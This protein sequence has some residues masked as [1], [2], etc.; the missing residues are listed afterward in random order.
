VIWRQAKR[1]R[2]RV[3]CGLGLRF[4][5]MATRL[6]RTQP[7]AVRKDPCGREARELLVFLP[8]VFD[9]VE[10]YEAHGFLQAVRETGRAVDMLL[11]DAHLGY[12]AARTVLE[13]LR[14]DVI[15][16]ARARYESIRLIGIS[17]GG[18]GALLYAARYPGHVTDVALLAP[19]LGKAG[20]IE[21]IRAAGGLR[22]WSPSPAGELEYQQEL[23]GWLKAYDPA[24]REGPRIVLGY[25]LQ[26]RTVPGLG[27][28]AGVLPG[29]HVFTSSGR[30]DWR[31]WTRL[32]RAMLP[33]VLPATG[34]E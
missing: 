24:S 13:R 2:R 19:F 33:T 10:D 8:G 27:L 17:M 6:P 22:S 26:D 12:Y 16:P 29:D 23:W 1:L 3:A 14:Q 25:G 28:L 15:D 21:D 20:V 34:R 5:G 18:L 11:V 30:H 9:V 31:T 32:W 7:L 4:P